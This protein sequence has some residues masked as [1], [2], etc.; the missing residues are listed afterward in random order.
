MILESKFLFF[1]FAHLC[2]EPDM[3]QMVLWLAGTSA[4]LT[5]YSFA[6]PLA[7]FIICLFILLNEETEI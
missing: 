6:H 3:S 4:V 1:K 2:I 7:F 5:I